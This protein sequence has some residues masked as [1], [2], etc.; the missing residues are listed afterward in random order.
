MRKGKSVAVLLLALLAM[1]SPLHAQGTCDLATADEFWTRG[2]GRYDAADYAGAVDDYTCGLQLDPDNAGLFNMRGNAYGELGDTDKA[3]ADYNQAVELERDE[4]YV[5]LYNRGTLYL[6]LRQ[7]DK[8]ESDFNTALTYNPDYSPVYVNRGNIYYE[9]GD[10]ARAIEDYGRAIELRD[11]EIH[12]PYYNRGN[13][14]YEL[15]DYSQALNDLS[16]SINANPSYALAFLSRAATY[17]VLGDDRAYDD[18]LQWVTLPAPNVV[19]RAFGAPVTAEGLAMVEDTVYSVTFT[20]QS[21]QEIN[22][23]ARAAVDSQV[24][25][26]LVILGPDGAALAADDDSGV[27][28]DAVIARFRAPASGEYTLL[29][30]HG[31][32]GSAGDLSLTLN[33]GG[34]PS[35]TFIVYELVVGHQA[36][37]YTT[38]G[39]RLNLRSGPGLNF[40]ILA[41]LDKGILVTLVEGPRKADSYVWWRIR[42]ETGTEGWSVERVEAEQTLQPALVVGGQA[43]VITGEALLNVR[44]GPGLSNVI[45]AKLDNGAVVTLLEAP[46]EADGL[47]WWKVRTE[48]GVEGWAVDSAEGERTLIGL[49]TPGG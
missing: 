18:Y 15:G 30:T 13:A 25:P 10:Y 21:G 38:G 47:R 41:K 14:Y 7:Y 45:L 32:G 35:Q 19:E 27:N 3:L 5:P 49:H 28:L 34:E 12:I 33:V 36:T 46:Q 9:Q 2:S 29:V 22:A 8:A 39:D 26:L 44:A 42:T 1:H 16:E 11:E 31:F 48:D 43:Q 24:D 37:V 17:Q 20:A 4:P 23:A 6:K 40:D